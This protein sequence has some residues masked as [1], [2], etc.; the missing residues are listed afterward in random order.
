[1]KRALCCHAF[2]ALLSVLPLCAQEIAGIWQGTLHA[3]PQSDQRIV[4]KIIGTDVSGCS[5]A[6]MWHCTSTACELI[7]VLARPASAP[8]IHSAR[9]VLQS[10]T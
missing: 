10:L 2:L 8:G 5:E 4:L 3:S 7:T 9:P 6:S 1:M